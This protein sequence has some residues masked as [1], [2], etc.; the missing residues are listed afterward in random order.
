MH[1]FV[2]LSC[3]SKFADLYRLYDT[4]R[5][6]IL[7]YHQTMANANPHEF[8]Y[9]ATLRSN[10]HD[11][12]TPHLGWKDVGFSL[13]EHEFGLAK[14]VEKNVK[15]VWVW[16][17]CLDFNVVICLNHRSTINSTH[18]DQSDENHFA[19]FHP[20]DARYFVMKGLVV[21]TGPLDVFRTLIGTGDIQALKNQMDNKVNGSAPQIFLLVCKVYSK[22][23]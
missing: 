16:F 18:N 10:C 6:S 7:S 2:Y 3:V 8:S 11:C 15:L 1:F 13:I 22:D 19:I 14:S 4:F 17:N 5:L 20:N 21:A 23:C 12:S 9:E